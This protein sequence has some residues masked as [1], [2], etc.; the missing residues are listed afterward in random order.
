M[1][2]VLDQAKARLKIFVKATTRKKKSLD[3]P[4]NFLSVSEDY[5]IFLPLKTKLIVF[6][7]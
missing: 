3:K 6:D 4:Q 2:G 5:R 1:C 7:N